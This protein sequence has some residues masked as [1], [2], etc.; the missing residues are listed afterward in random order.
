MGADGE[1]IRN[2]QYLRRNMTEAE[3]IMWRSLRNRQV[4]G[5]KFRRQ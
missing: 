5:L 3:K 1:A 2:A 4:A